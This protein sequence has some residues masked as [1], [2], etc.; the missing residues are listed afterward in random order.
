MTKISP[1]RD[2]Y[3][4]SSEITGL[5][6]EKKTLYFAQISRTSPEIIFVQNNKTVHEKG[7]FASYKTT[8]LLLPSPLPPKQNKEAL[9]TVLIT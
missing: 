9:L 8:R 5:V 3:P 4:P 6:L 1:E 7:Y 2:I